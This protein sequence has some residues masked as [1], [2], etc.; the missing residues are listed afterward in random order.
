MYKSRK[1]DRSFGAEPAPVLHFFLLL[2]G[3]TSV[4]K[5]MASFADVAL[6]T[7]AHPKAYIHKSISVV[8]RAQDETKATSVR[9]QVASNLKSNL[10]PSG[11]LRCPVPLSRRILMD[12]RRLLS[13]LYDNWVPF[14]ALPPLR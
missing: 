1:A 10:D 6:Q 12:L 11:G 4:R 14:T 5:F 3:N 7:R 8:H 9:A 13:R 2:T